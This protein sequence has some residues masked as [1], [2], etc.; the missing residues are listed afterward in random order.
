MNSKF[1]SMPGGGGGEPDEK[2]FDGTD[3]SFVGR[4]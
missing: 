2:D 1:C 3:I 4:T